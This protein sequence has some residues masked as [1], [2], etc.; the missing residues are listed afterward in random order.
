MCTLFSGV[1]RVTQKIPPPKSPL[2]AILANLIHIFIRL[3]GFSPFWAVFSTLAVVVTV[4]MN[5]H[6]G[7]RN[8][9]PKEVLTGAHHFFGGV[10]K[11]Y[12]I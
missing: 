8:L 12:I 5:V 10:F 11:S 4:L 6:P 9:V 2:V 1:C 7:D 3:R